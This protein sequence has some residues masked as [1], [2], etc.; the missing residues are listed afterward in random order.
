MIDLKTILYPT[1]FS[2]FSANAEPYVIEFAKKFGAKVVLV[3][4]VSVP[5]YAVSYEIAV[6]V[7]SLRET[8]EASAKKRIE[9]TAKRLKAEGIE[10]ETVLRIGTS[11]VEIIEAARQHEA[12]LIILPTHGWG[13]VKHLLLGSTAEKVV[14]KAPCPVM[15]IRD[16]EHDFIRP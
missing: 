15:T 14:R 3:H 13:A 9:E 4:V 1:D 2:E 8:M 16:P 7:V 10:V 11:F 5:A 6:D 12:Q